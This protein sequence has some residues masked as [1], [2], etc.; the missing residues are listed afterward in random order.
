M[1]LNRQRWIG[2]I[3]SLSL[4]LAPVQ[5]AWAEESL[6]D[7]L[8]SLQNQAA[9]Q[10]QKTNKVQSRMDTISEQLRQLQAEAD[11]ATAAYQT[12]RDQLNATETKI[13]DNQTLLEK[14]EQELAV[15]SKLLERR[16]RDIYIHGQL[17]YI[18]VLFGAQDFSDFMTRMDILKRIIKYDYDLVSKVQQ[19]R[20]TVVTARDALEKDKAAQVLLVADAKSKR[21]DMLDK[22]RAKDRLMDKM[23]YDRDTS[24][25]AY[26]E[27]I[28]ASKQVENLIRMS[29]YQYAGSP[30]GSG[31]MIWPISGEI[32]SPFGWRVHPITG[33]SR[34]HS[35][36]D[37][38]GD[39]GDPIRAAAAGTVIYAGW[40]S[41]YGNAVILDNGGGVTT[42]YG[43][44]QSLAVSE[45]QTVA[46]GQVISY[47]GSTGNSTGPHC[48]FEVRVNGEPVSPLSYL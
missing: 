2:A 20:Q 4:L 33:D 30:S 6:E 11:D 12:V 38:A 15:K 17:S 3:L 19:D 5:A 41:G 35:G 23:R 8:E 16:V 46:Q 34:F 40:I 27:L 22:K 28:A 48:H 13:D 29:R 21:D 32:T 31:A 45:G 10:Q 9:E 18:D 42:L 26:Q 37:I 44:N 14:T 39:Y 7:K 36:I 25:R 43:H 47:C 1:K 24:E